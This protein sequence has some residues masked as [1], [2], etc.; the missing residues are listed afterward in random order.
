[1]SK[2]IRYQIPTNYNLKKG[3]KALITPFKV[4]QVSTEKRKDGKEVLLFSV[5]DKAEATR[6]EELLDQRNVKFKR[7]E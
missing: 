7:L 2:S 4:R 6:I 1:M 3:H 5:K